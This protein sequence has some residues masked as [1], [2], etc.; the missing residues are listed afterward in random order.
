MNK[1]VG[2]NKPLLL[3][4]AIRPPSPR[5][6][7]RVLRKRKDWLTARCAIADA[8]GVMSNTKQILE[9]ELAALDW[10]IGELGK[11]YPPIPVLD[12]DVARAVR[13][14]CTCGREKKPKSMLCYVCWQAEIREEGSKR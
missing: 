7:L 6:C 4:P 1:K 3:A 14:R 9:E 10:A 8:T 2:T 5:R 11:L 12:P 13:E